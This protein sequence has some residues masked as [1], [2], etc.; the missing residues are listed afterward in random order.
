MGLGPSM[1]PTME[2]RYVIRPD[3][4]GYT[5]RDLWTGEPAHLA[6][7]PQV[8]LSQDDAEHTAE[9]LNSASETASLRTATDE[10]RQTS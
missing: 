1:M 2:T 3:G 9:L 4:Q 10:I 7:A 6:G 5:V 8:G